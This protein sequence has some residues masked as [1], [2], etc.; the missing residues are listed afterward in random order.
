MTD[1]FSYPYGLIP[2]ATSVLLVTVDVVSSFQDLLFG[3]V[4]PPLAVGGYGHVLFSY[5]AGAVTAYTAPILI[6][7]SPFIIAIP[8]DL[9]N[10][11]PAFLIEPYNQ[12]TISGNVITL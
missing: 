12:N 10:I 11:T 3:T 4:G 1:G 2:S 7:V 5:T 6:P 9:A 8:N